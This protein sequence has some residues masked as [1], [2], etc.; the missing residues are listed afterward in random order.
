MVRVCRGARGVGVTWHGQVV[1]HAEFIRNTDNACSC[2]EL[3]DFYFRPFTWIND[4]N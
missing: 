3:P 1:C 4:A 2:H